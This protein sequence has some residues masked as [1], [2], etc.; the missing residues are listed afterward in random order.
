[1][2]SCSWRSTQNRTKYFGMWLLRTATV[3]RKCYP[4]YLVSSSAELRTF[5]L[6]FNCCKNTVLLKSNW[7]TG[8]SHFKKKLPEKNTK[9]IWSLT[10]NLCENLM[11]NPNWQH[12]NK[13]VTTP[14]TNVIR[15]CFKINLITLA[16]NEYLYMP[17][18]LGG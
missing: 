2:W 14:E 15:I 1:M 3:T 4:A 18:Y 6:H 13:C 17:A 11:S 16:W 8:I 5:W 10:L 7:F 9:Y 12:E